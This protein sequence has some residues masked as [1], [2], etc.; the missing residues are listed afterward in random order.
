MRPL[1]PV[2]GSECSVEKVEKA[3]GLSFDVID[4]VLGA[5]A[6][7]DGVK[8]QWTYKDVHHRFISTSDEHWDFSELAQHLIDRERTTGLSFF[9]KTEA[10]EVTGVFVELAGGMPA[11]WNPGK[12]EQCPV[13]MGR[14]ARK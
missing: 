9:M 13:R 7:Q 3:T 14:K 8:P 4:R 1:F 12:S 11:S 10:N 2:D 5:N 6:K